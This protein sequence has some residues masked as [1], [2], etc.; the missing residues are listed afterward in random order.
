LDSIENRLRT[1]LADRYRLEREIGRGGMATVYL[2]ADLKHG[3]KV[4]IKVLAPELSA[5]L[6][7]ERFQ[8]EVAF[9]AGLQHPHILTVLDS[10]SGDGLTYYV[11]PFVEGESLRA[12]LDREGQ[13][14]VDQALELASEVA[15]ALDYAHRKGIVHRDIKPENILLADGQGMIS[16]FG[17][18]RAIRAAGGTQLTQSG[19]TLG[20]PPYMSPEQLVGERELDGRS[21]IYSL[22]CVLYEMLAGQ[23]PFSGP[24]Q[25]LAHQHL[26]VEPRP[27]SDLRP[28]VPPEL[29][30]AL[31]RAL[32]KAPADRF[33][34]AGEFADAL[35]SIAPPENAATLAMR[36]AGVGA[37][38]P[39]AATT[40]AMRIEPAGW[41]PDPR[42]TAPMRV[43]GLAAVI[44][45]AAAIG[46]WAARSLTQHRAMDGST[47]TPRKWVWLAAFDGP[48]D[49]PELAPTARDLVAATLDQSKLLAVVPEQQARIA[50]RNAGRPDSSRV[51][52]ALARELA[53]RSSIP[54]VV[55]G[56]VG[57]IGSGYSI[58][59]KASSAADGRSLLSLEDQA[60]DAAALIPSLAR[61]SRRLR[62]GL[63]E[64]AADLRAAQVLGD[65]ATP[66]FEA[67]KLYARARDLNAAGEPFEAIPMLRRAIA[68]D[69]EFASAW[70]MLGTVFGNIGQPDSAV[71]AYVEAQ[72]HP[73]RLRETQRLEVEASQAMFGA[74]LQAAIS[75]Y[76]A[77]LKLDPSPAEASAALNN[78]GVCFSLLGDDE[79]ALE[80][81][82]RSGPVWPV[83]PPSI[84][85]G[86]LADA[87]VAMNRL[88]EARSELAHFEN[89]WPGRSL[90]IEILLLERN[91]RRADS[92]STALAAD[93]TVP[94]PLRQ[95]ATSARLSLVAERGELEAAA[96]GLDQLQ[97]QMTNSSGLGPAFSTWL[98]RS[99]LAEVRGR[100]I[101]A[102]LDAANPG[103][104]A[105]AGSVRAAM[106]GDS[107]EAR[108]TLMSWQSTVGLR[109]WVKDAAL[110]YV[111]ARADSRLERWD[112]VV[113]SLRANAACGTRNEP[114]PLAALRL[115]SRWMIADAFQSLGQPDSARYYLERI[116]DPPGNHT[117]LLVARGFAEPFVRQR[118]VHLNLALGRLAEARRQ[119]DE[120]AATCVHPDPPLA[121][122]MNETRSALL[123]AEGMGAGARK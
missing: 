46:W 31:Q 6:G 10:G 9:A 79:R 19:M 57:R 26:N 70:M 110:N 28:A 60:A 100:P 75:F 123:A 20:T 58:V 30:R 50:L 119:W 40:A 118:L 32:A 56:R 111:Q 39:P 95:S 116:L 120:L 24:P 107:S 3:R 85:W 103:M 7:V 122:S 49:D 4:A 36:T 117:T 18:A 88:T 45:A 91:A 41:T 102:K 97:T 64:R 84:Y 59:L 98:Q 74:D 89:T 12:R 66:S 47:L 34:N 115:P 87:H 13:L 99:W 114:P 83:Q 63:G 35:R 109:R 55:E 62:Q 105:L 52:A 78:L 38:G 29:A 51:D 69:P 14:P 90:L 42:R 43:L 86:N 73:A 16:D 61:V 67:F 15:R 121:A 54:V 23:P 94:L 92:L 8:Q 101:P 71:A 44:V 104:Q 2:A 108:R 53:Y 80:F 96:R 37:A 112:R 11:M 106:M 21:D 77:L 27:V 81:Y 1:A 76:D 48:A 93:A 72:R 113:E 25:S 5:M 68:L 17:L 65:A 22:G 82:R 33:G